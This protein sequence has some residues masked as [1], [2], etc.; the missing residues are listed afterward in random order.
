MGLDPFLYTF[1]GEVYTLGVK[2]TRKG[3][4]QW[5]ALSWPCRLLPPFDALSR[6]PVLSDIEQPS[7]TY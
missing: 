5:L 2:C 3:L 1:F 4:R 6:Q 7:A